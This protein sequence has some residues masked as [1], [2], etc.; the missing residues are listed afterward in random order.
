MWRVKERTFEQGE[1]A[2]ERAVA[3]Y[4]LDR[5][6]PPDVAL[7]AA[8]Y[9][10]LPRSGEPAALYRGDGKGGFTDVA[11]DGNDCSC[12]AAGRGAGAAGP[13]LGSGFAGALLALRRRRG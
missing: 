2:G 4:G 7:V 1:E 9:L 8:D 11:M 12:S 5:L 3:G 13:A 6:T 10:G